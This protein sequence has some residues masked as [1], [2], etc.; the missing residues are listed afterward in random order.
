MIGVG[1]AIAQGLGLAGQFASGLMSAQARQ[2]EFAEQL[3]RLEMQKRQT[4]GLATAK[5]GASGVEFTSASTQQ[6]LASLASEFDRSI[7]N[8]RDVG[9]VTSMTDML[10][11]FSNLLGGSA[12]LV[13]SL[14]KA[15]NWDFGGGAKPVYTPGQGMPLWRP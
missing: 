2:G 8:L 15:N 10:G 9:R 14:G 13:G 6:Y 4:V 5:T 1:F 12:G 3:R 7:D 11:A